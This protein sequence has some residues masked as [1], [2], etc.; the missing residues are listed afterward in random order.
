MAKRASSPPLCDEEET[1]KSHNI[2]SQKKPVRPPVAIV[3]EDEIEE[4]LRKDERPQPP[5]N[6]LW[7]GIYS[8]PWQPEHLRAWFLFGLGLSA[9]AFL[10]TAVCHMTYLLELSKSDFEW[11]MYRTLSRY[12]VAALM[13]AIIWTG[14]FAASYFLEL[15]QQTA[16]G[17]EEFDPPDD[18]IAE[19]IGNFLYLAWIAFCTLAPVGA[20]S[21]LLAGLT[22][23]PDL[24]GVPLDSQQALIA[25]V[26][27]RGLIVA[28]YLLLSVFVYPHV[29]LG[30]LAN[31]SWV[32]LLSDKVSIGLLKRPLIL[33]VLYTVSVLLMA[34]CLALG[35]MTILGL[36][37]WLAPVTGFVWSAALLIYGRLLGRVGWL[38]TDGDEPTT[39]RR[40]KRKRRKRRPTS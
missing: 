14:S 20:L 1:E 39:V 33:L 27:W 37:Y 15:I 34:P 2:S 22:R 36:Q 9:I 21:Y 25:A 17:N 28:G 35:V 31:K 8:C 19:K 6:P 38:L 3:T 29:L 7:Q 40:R 10:A 12:F 23:R 11:S 16:G 32:W 18:M 24:Q 26:I 13:G 30:A 5:A 4:E